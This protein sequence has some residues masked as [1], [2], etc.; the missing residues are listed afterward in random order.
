MKES[1]FYRLSLALPLAVPLLVAPLL[2]FGVRLPEWLAWAAL[3]TTFSGIIGGLPYL[4]VI[5]VL[6]CW[7]RR[8]TET[9]FKRALA[10]SPILMLPV[11]GAILALAWSG[12]AWLRPENALPLSDRFV[13]FLGLV[14]FILGFGY[15]Y[16]VLVFSTA[17]IL[18]RRGMLIPSNAI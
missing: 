2:F 9:Q 11:V 15:F 7:A 18:K 12:E 6:L 17:W 5:A 13:G 14:P 4:I 1:K 16:V 3:Y 10:W 8:K